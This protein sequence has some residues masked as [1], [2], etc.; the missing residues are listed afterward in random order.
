MLPRQGS[1]SWRVVSA[2][3]RSHT[4]RGR[5]VHRMKAFFRLLPLSLLLLICLSVSPL[6]A[7]D[8]V[9]T[10][11]NLGADRIRLAAA[12]FKP[13]GGDPQTP[14][15]KTIFDATFYSDLAGAG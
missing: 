2:A 8:W 7:Q 15:L 4:A 11:T 14:S 3:R 6:R 10:G 5:T 1:K 9:H 12:D 13:M